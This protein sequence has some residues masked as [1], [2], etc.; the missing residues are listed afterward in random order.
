MK[1]Q[2]Q[3]NN[4]WKLYTDGKSGNKRLDKTARKEAVKLRKYRQGGKRELWGN[5]A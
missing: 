2:S 5:M 3:P 4:S 1:N